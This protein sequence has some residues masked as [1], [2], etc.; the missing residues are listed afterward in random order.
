MNEDIASAV[1]VFRASPDLGDHAVYLALVAGGMDRQRAA[2]L[3]EFLPMVY[4]RLLLRNSGARFPNTFCRMQPDGASME[5]LLSSEPVWIAA[6][7]FARAELEHGVSSQDLMAV[8]ARSSEF[9]AA[10]R[11]LNKGSMLKDITFASPVLT[12]PENGPDE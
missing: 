3:V 5:Q 4:C 7:A 6:M 10:N 12:W 8:A 1:S 9:D 11:L 2:R